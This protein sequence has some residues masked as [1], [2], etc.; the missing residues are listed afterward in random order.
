MQP[1]V[2][3]TTRQVIHSPF[4]YLPVTLHT[5]TRRCTHA[6]TH[7]RRQRFWLIRSSPPAATLQQRRARRRT[8]PGRTAPGAETS[9]HA[10]RSFPRPRAAARRTRPFRTR[11]R[12]FQRV[13]RHGSSGRTRRLTGWSPRRRP[14]WPR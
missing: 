2:H 12:G 8:C 11:R 4:I 7:I 9:S 13:V 6:R 14:R 5:P 3:D 10:R 1:L